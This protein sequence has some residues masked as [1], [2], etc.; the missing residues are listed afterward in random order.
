MPLTALNP[1]QKPDPSSFTADA[2]GQARFHARVD[3]HLL[4]ATQVFYAIIYHFDV[5][6]YHPLPN[7]GEFFTQGDDCRSTFGEDAMRQII[8]FQ[9]F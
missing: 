5:M 2:D 6:T 9:K 3:G 1:K 4:D 8:V 7:L